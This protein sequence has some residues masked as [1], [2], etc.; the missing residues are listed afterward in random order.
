MNNTWKLSIMG[1]I[2]LAA[3]S[4]VMV[5]GCTVTTTSGP[6]GDGGLDGSTGDGAVTTDGGG[7]EGGTMCSATA[8][9]PII[10]S[11]TGISFD[12]PQCGDCDKCTAAK[13]CDEATK[14]FTKVDGGNSECEDMLGCIS[15]CAKPND[16][17][18]TLDQCK[19]NCR[20][21]YPQGYTDLVAIDSCQSTDTDAG[22]APGKCQVECQ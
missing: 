17:G 7:G 15:D 9:C 11:S 2:A 5:V 13:C 21:A 8:M 22:A 1:A 10:A 6:L 14:C 16:A 12:N 3:S 19:T 20:A 4:T 18:I